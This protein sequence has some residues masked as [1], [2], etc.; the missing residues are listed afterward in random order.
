[1]SGA[2]AGVATSD[3]RATDAAAAVLDTGGNAVDAA[4]TAA[5]VLFVVEPHFCGVAG[6]AFAMVADGS[7][8]PVA[9]DGSGALPAA[10]SEARLR[11][12]GLDTVPA[13][14]GRSVS[15]PG[16]VDLLATLLTRHGQLTLAD[17]IAPATALASDGFAV[18]STLANAA[19]RAAGEIGQDPVLGPLYVPDGLPVAAGDVVHNPAL[20]ACLS[21]LAAE[22]A[23]P[24]Y[25]GDLAAALADTVRDDGGY[26]TADDLAAHETVTMAP[27]RAGLCGCSVWELPTPTQGPAVVHALDAL[28]GTAA[29]EGEV[30]WD[31]VLDATRAGMVATGFDP[32]AM[33]P[34]P[35]PAK[36][37][38]TYLAVV[39]HDGL[40]VSLI[41]S[42]FGD[43]GSHLGVAALGGA[44]H[45]RATTL[46]MLHSPPTPGKP[47][48]TTIPAM[49]TDAD[50]SPRLCL[51]VAGG[52]MQ[53]QAQVQVLVRTLVED[54]PLQ[55]AIDAPRFKVCFGGDLALEPGHPLGRQ[56]PAALGRDPGP[57]GFGSAQA[58][59][60][61]HGALEAA[62][63]ARRGGA[64]RLLAR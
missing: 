52:I 53:P 8:P 29:L 24:L 3:P 35:A 50:G 57:E 48:H 18:R 1:V 27:A 49:V 51:G 11:D 33:G 55:A 34:R 22:G 58:V 20:A 9:Y 23:G 44:V 64:A 38:T 41:T 2:S 6:D 32:V 47:P 19:R 17:A 4:V 14:G 7:G 59:G 16:A 30:E 5:F 43:F 56:H 15:V 31:A 25:R 54:L 36:G 61:R 42:L 37:D 40:A 26:L 21:T 13:R 60:R 62:A 12:D 10:L 28:D 39:D 45:N 46:R 63:D